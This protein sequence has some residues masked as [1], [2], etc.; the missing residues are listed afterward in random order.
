MGL[1][2]PESGSE[3]GGRSLYPQGMNSVEALL[4]AARR[5]CLEQHQSWT[6][7]YAELQEGREG[8]IPYTYTDEDLDTFPRYHVLDAILVEVERFVAGDFESF[9]EAR[10]LLLAAVAS[11]ESMFTTGGGSIKRRAMDEE[12]EGV[13]EYLREL[14]PSQLSSVEPLPFRRTLED[15]EAADL[16]RRLRETWGAEGYWYP[17]AE[18][19]RKDVEAFQARYLLEGDTVVRLREALTQRGVETVFALR[20]VEPDWEAEVGLMDLEYDSETY[21]FDNSLDWI[22]YV[23]HESSIT[24]GGWLLQVL[25]GG[26][27]DWRRRVWTTP[28]YD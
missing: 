10:A 3:D 13:A 28:F 9:D 26:W 8:R 22:I 18:N 7:R 16:R 11:A 4:T 2:P 12:R 1:E 23:S 24:V 5:Y 15:A 25:Q 6:E 17:L 27:P 21:W 19:E 14:T 20:E